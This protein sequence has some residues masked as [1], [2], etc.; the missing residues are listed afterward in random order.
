M[1]HAPTAGGDETADD[2]LS[3]TPVATSRRDAPSAWDDGTP[4]RPRR[5]AVAGWALENVADPGDLDVVDL[6]SSPSPAPSAPVVVATDQVTKPRATRTVRTPRAALVVGGGIAAL[7]A[8]V[9][10][11]GTAV[12]PP[13]GALAAVLGLARNTKAGAR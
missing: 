1:V 12:L 8:A 4:L 13:L 11:L 10:L 2:I 7:A 6:L 5:G 3:V 9:W